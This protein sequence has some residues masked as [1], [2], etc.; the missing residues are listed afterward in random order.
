MKHQKEMYSFL[1]IM[2][3]EKHHLRQIE[4]QLR[5]LSQNPD[6]IQKKFKE[7]SDALEEEKG[8]PADK[9][10]VK[11]IQAQ[12]QKKQDNF[13]QILNQRLDKL[14]TEMAVLKNSSAEFQQRLNG[15]ADSVN[16]Q[17][18]FTY[19]ICKK[20]DLFM[21]ESQSSDPFAVAPRNGPPPKR[22]D[23]QIGSA[24]DPFSVQGGGGGDA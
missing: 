6:V 7:S 12:I 21:K 23:R 10:D 8:L 15:W 14:T 24:S 13:V 11:K 2:D 9:G 20:A 19:A 16:G 17:L 1:D 5:S 18:R 3:A 22:P 4:L